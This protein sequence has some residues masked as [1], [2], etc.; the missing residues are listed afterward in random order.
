[1][2]HEVVCFCKGK[3]CPCASSQCH[4]DAF[5]TLGEPR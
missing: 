2:Q 3:G 4:E 5:L 1:M